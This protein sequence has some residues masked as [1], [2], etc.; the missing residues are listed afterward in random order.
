MALAQISSLTAP[1]IAPAF[2]PILVGALVV[3]K[4]S[5]GN[6]F[7]NLVRYSDNLIVDSQSL[8][9]DQGGGKFFILGATMPAQPTYFIVQAGHENI[10]DDLQNFLVGI[11]GT[12]DGRIPP[13][14]ATHLLQLNVFVPIIFVDLESYVLQEVARVVFGLQGLNVLRVDWIPDK[15][16]FLIWLE[17]SSPATVRT[18]IV[19]A[20]IAAIVAALIPVFIFIGVVVIGPLLINL[21]SQGVEYVKTVAKGEILKNTIDAQD[22]ILNNPNLTDQQKKEAIG[23]LQRFY[24]QAVQGD[25]PWT[26]LVAG[27]V[28]AAIGIAY[29]ASKRR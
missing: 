13:L 23:V 16:R 7:V 1:T 21:A 15:S 24:E 28:A 2:S 10:V 19:P 9:L 29:I 4:G 11:Y 17:A 5:A 25:L 8:F 26:L 22:R 27:G 14:F 3:N 12:Y 18:F 6:I 20:V